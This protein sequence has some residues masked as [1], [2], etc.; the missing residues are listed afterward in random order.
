MAGLWAALGTS[1][2]GLSRTT[3]MIHTQDSPS[4]DSF[5]ATWGKNERGVVWQQP[6]VPM[7]DN[8]DT[9]QAKLPGNT[10]AEQIQVL[11]KP[12]LAATISEVTF[13]NSWGQL[14]REVGSEALQVIVGSSERTAK[15]LSVTASSRRS[16]EIGVPGVADEGRDWFMYWP[17]VENILLI[18]GSMLVGGFVSGRLAQRVATPVLLN[19]SLVILGTVVGLGVMEGIGRFLLPS[20]RTYYPWPP[21]L[22]QVFEPIP[23][24]MP[25]ITGL[26]NFITNAQG[27]RGDEINSAADYAILAIGGSTTECL[28][29][30]QT[31][32]WP[33]LVQDRL[34]QQNDGWQVWV[35]NAGRSGRTTREYSVMMKYLLPQYPQIDT[36]IVLTGINDLSQWLLQGEAYE[37]ALSDPNAEQA[38]IERTFEHIAF[39][40]PFLPLYQRSA[41]WRLVSGAVASRQAAET[42]EDIY[43]EDKVGRNYILRRE[44]RQQA[45][46]QEALPDMTAA[47]DEY[48]RNLATMAELAKSDGVRL[49]LMTQPVLWHNDLSQAEENLLWFGSGPDGT[50]FYSV[51]ALMT[52]MAAFNE[53]TRAACS[54]YEIECVDLATMLSQDTTTFYDDVH[55]NEGGAAKVATVVSDYLLAQ[56]PF[57]ETQEP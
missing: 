21:H 19:V 18:V 2:A 49:I 27:I 32:A 36:V 57:S 39:Q 41:L 40:D 23:D 16:A 43:V 51:E 3:V 52:G 13:R 9:W 34:N 28:Y 11:L 33:Q 14:Y 45:P 55:F 56:P 5:S 31:E 37:A 10:R 26:S 46:I 20:P 50:F 35:G 53:R 24:V 8:A 4:P 22:H 42:V 48:G 15:G 1:P 7:D 47:L 44:E 54:L 12:G 38:L 29:L 25:G 17:L 30:D 6:F